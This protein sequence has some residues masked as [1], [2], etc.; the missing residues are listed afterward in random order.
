MDRIDV[1]GSIPS[2]AAWRRGA[3]LIV[4]VSPGAVI[5]RGARSEPRGAHYIEHARGKAEQEEYHEPPGRDAEPAVNEPAETGTDHD[6]CNKFAGE[7]KASGVAGCSRCPIR[8][9]T[10]G[11]LAASG[12]AKTFVQP[13]ESRGESGLVG[14]LLAP[15]PVFARIA[16]AFGTRGLRSRHARTLKPRGPY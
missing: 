10:I 7:P 16:H 3:G 15:V 9:R 11:R 8:P 12:T 6:A 14:L 4:P 5:K 13:L 1:H 2:P